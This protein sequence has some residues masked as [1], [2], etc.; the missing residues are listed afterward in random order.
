MAMRSSWEGFLKLSLVLV[1]V[2]AYNAAVPGGGEKLRQPDSV[3]ESLPS[4]WRGEQGRNRVGLRIRERQI[5]GA[6]TGGDF[7]IARRQRPVDQYR[8]FHRPEEID[9]I[10]MSGKT[11][12]L[13][14]AGHCTS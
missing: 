1:P 9:P 13:V 5:R 11:L 10:Y 6:G 2:R 8:R 4:A 7:Q 12:F 3:P 14:P